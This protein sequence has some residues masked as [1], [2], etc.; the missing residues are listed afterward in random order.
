MMVLAG[1]YG[2]ENGFKKRTKNIYKFFFNYKYLKN[3]YIE[4]LS[5]FGVLPDLL[6]GFKVF[7]TVSRE[8]VVFSDIILMANFVY[9]TILNALN[10][11]VPW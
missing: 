1:L 5:N 11:E 4:S 2:F 8:R 3:L 6:P 7:Y 10:R 9:A